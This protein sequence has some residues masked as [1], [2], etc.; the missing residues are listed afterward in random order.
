MKPP[1]KTPLGRLL[2]TMGIGYPK[3]SQRTGIQI[4][5]LYNLATGSNRSGVARSCVERALGVPVWS[6]AV[7]E[8]CSAPALPPTNLVEIQPTALD[9]LLNKLCPDRMELCDELARW[10]DPKDGDGFA[11]ENRMEIHRYLNDLRFGA[12]NWNGE[13]GW[14][15]Y[16]GRTILWLVTH[17]AKISAVIAMDA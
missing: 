6:Q 15:R 4:Q 1:T 10:F 11:T 16:D 13:D 2:A 9:A 12:L 3:L 17:A 7:Y 8:D 5:Q 14:P